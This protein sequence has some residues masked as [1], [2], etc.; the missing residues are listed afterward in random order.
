MF[1]LWVVGEAEASGFYRVSHKT[2][3]A[4]TQEPSAPN[5]MPP[6]MPSILWAR[7]RC[8]WACCS[9][10]CSSMRACWFVIQY[11]LW[12]VDGSIVKEFLALS[13]CCVKELVTICN[14][15]WVIVGAGGW[16][17]AL[18]TA[19]ASARIEHGR[20]LFVGSCGWLFLSDSKSKKYYI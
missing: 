10:A 16:W 13:T 18:T 19:H 5:K 1:C 17:L 20:A 6:T 9:A 11:F 3:A 15:A 14:K 4:S 2:M 7:S 12:V 8:A